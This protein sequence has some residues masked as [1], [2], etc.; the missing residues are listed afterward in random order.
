LEKQRWVVSGNPNHDVA[1]FTEKTA[2]DTA[3]VVMVEDN[4]AVWHFADRAHASLLGE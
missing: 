2:H 1:W 3:V 4:F